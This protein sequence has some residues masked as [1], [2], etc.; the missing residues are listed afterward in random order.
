MN[1]TLDF[2]ATNL[3]ARCVQEMEKH[4]KYDQAHAAEHFDSV[5]E[6]YE[7][8]Y[9]RAGY[10][11]P[12]KVQEYVS[13][14]ASK[15]V[16]P[17]HLAQICDFACGTGLVGQNLKEAGFQNI[18]GIDI[19]PKMLQKAEE[20]G[21]Y[22][23][24]L[25]LQLNQEEHVDSVP[26]GQR[27]KYDFVT[28]AGLINNNFLDLRI[29]E[30]MLIC[31]KPGGYLVFS[32]RFSY[33]GQYWYT[34]ALAELEKAGR[35]KFIQDESFFKYDQLTVSVGKFTKTPVRVYVYQK[36]ENDS[37]FACKNK[38][39]LSSMSAATADSDNM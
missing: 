36:T 30:Q 5:A 37:V 17:K 31:L 28:A 13:K 22:T 24:L 19:S 20:K 12:K 6:H 25:N 39:K 38:Q 1:S 4:N 35:I 16:I 15:Q 21:C 2:S 18:C 33:L 27:G 23:N 11:D 9:Q 3:D 32:A 34:D 29:F 7:G 14:I 8:A 26:H 10:P